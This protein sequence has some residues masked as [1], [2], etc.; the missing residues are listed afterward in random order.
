MGKLTQQDVRRVAAE[1]N[2]D[3]RTVARAFEGARQ[4]AAVR[5]AIVAALAKLGFK[6]QA[7]ALGAQKG[8]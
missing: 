5:S 6:S 1:A 8:G 2:V 4:S 7:R 3:P